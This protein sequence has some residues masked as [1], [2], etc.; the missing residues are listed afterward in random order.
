MKCSSLSQTSL[1]ILPDCRSFSSGHRAHPRKPNSGWPPRPPGIILK[2]VGAGSVVLVCPWS[3]YNRTASA[4]A[5]MAGARRVQGSIRPWLRRL[6]TAVAPQGAE[7]GNEQIPV[8]GSVASAHGG[9]LTA[10]GYIGGN[11]IKSPRRKCYRIRL[12]ARCRTFLVSLGSF[13]MPGP[14]ETLSI[15]TR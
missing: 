10:L 4:L 15:Q 9:S 2:G 14:N 7:A 11:A 13:R 8:I 6:G 5:T 12:S 3:D 1:R